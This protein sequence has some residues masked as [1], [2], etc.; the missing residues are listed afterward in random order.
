M[1]RVKL[2]RRRAFTLVELLVVIAI[3]GI[4]IA[5]LLPA[6]QKVREAANR[7]KCNNNIRQIALG[8]H[9]CNDAVGVMPPYDCLPA[10]DSAGV[11]HNVIASSNYF[12]GKF[13]RGTWCF[14]L[15]PFIE[16]ADLYKAG[17]WGYPNPAPQVGNASY[18]DYDVTLPT[19]VSTGAL[20]V[21]G[22][23]EPPNSLTP[24]TFSAPVYPVFPIVGSSAV[25]VY[26]CPSDPTF[27][28][29][30]GITNVDPDNWQ[31]N[32]LPPNNTQTSTIQGNYGACSYACNYLC[33]GAPYATPFEPSNPWNSS[34]VNPDGFN[35][36]AATFSIAGS[37]TPRL[38]GTFQDGTSNTILFAE[39]FAQNCNWTLAGTLT[40]STTWINGGN[41]WA[42]A[43]QT[44][45]WAPAFAM[46]SPW[47][48]GTRFQINPASDQCNV[49]YAQ[50]GHTGGMV[51]AM[52][53]GSART[54]SANI[55]S[56]TFQNLC[57]P[58]G[59]EIIGPDF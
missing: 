56:A 54:L 59:G 40:Q 25:K 4:L 29:T 3:I 46:E 15:L 57:T 33:F 23:N 27:P 8:C 30:G 43:V 21:A 42:P 41:L 38:P 35:P 53:D 16:G 58:N 1:F 19:P 5:L 2:F 55:S 49:A 36:T 28:G 52:A 47:S 31:N 39:K 50:T 11:I 45:Q 48:D 6:V 26:Q 9:N 7:I 17:Q 12:G 14:F 32:T 22:G 37:T 13:N 10:A 34:V 24:G 18:Y 44:A 20:Q 51:I